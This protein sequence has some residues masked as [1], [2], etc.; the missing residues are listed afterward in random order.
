MATRIPNYKVAS[1]IP[2]GVICSRSP[3]RA[4]FDYTSH[5]THRKNLLPR[6]KV[7][8]PSVMATTASPL[9]MI[10]LFIWASAL[11]SPVRLWAYLWETHQRWSEVFEP[12]LVI[13]VQ[14]RLVVIDEDRRVICM[15]FTRQAPRTRRSFLTVS[16]IFG[17]I[18]SNPIQ[19]GMLNVRYSVCDFTLYFLSTCVST[20]ITDLMQQATKITL[21]TTYKRDEQGRVIGCSM[22]VRLIRKNSAKKSLS[23]RESAPCLV[24]NLCTRIAKSA[25]RLAVLSSVGGNGHSCT[26]Q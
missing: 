23:P 15:A 13:L 11:S 18:F 22:Y 24:N 19:A 10:C 1:L 20:R 25:E 4:R 26:L 5:Q 3:S 16:S 2:R 6:P 9:P 12:F 8:L 14:S 21:P 7:S 17:V